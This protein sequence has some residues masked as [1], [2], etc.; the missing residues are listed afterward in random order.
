MVDCTKL[1]R[2]QQ[3]KTP[4]SCFDLDLFTK[5]Q[6][7]ICIEIKPKCG[8]LPAGNLVGDE[9]KTR[10][11]RFQLHQPL[12]LLN[13]KTLRISKYGPLDLFSGE[14]SKALRALDNLIETLQNNFRLFVDGRKICTNDNSVCREVL[15]KILSEMKHSPPSVAEFFSVLADVLIQEPLLDRLK[16][17]QQLDAFDIE[18]VFPVFKLL[19]ENENLSNLWSLFQKIDKAV[20][21][22]YEDRLKATS[23]NYEEKLEKLDCCV[24]ILNKL[25][26]KNDNEV[27]HKRYQRLLNVS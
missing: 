23:E 15:E 22:N 21:A 20:C 14:K 12:K 16:R 11:S 1:T 25:I 13:K 19:L 26:V 27:V 3:S 10:V 2:A 8:F 7:D 17:A 18:Q 4:F 5:D 6:S 9:L 24:Q